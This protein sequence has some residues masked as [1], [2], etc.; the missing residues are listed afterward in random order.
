MFLRFLNSEVVSTNSAYKM[1]K[2]L[3]EKVKKN[4]IIVAFG[5]TPLLITKEW[6][7]KQNLEPIICNGYDK[8]R[9][10]IFQYYVFKVK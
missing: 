7:E 5:H 9:D 3:K 8:D 2:V 10:A 1:F 4:G 6:I